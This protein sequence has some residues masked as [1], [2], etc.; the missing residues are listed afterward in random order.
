SAG[1]VTFYRLTCSTIPDQ[2]HHDGRGGQ[3]ADKPEHDRADAL[4]R[5][6]QRNRIGVI[7][8][9]ALHEFSPKWMPASARSGPD[10]RIGRPLGIEL[11]NRLPQELTSRS[12]H[13]AE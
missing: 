5:L 8:P 10:F 13:R 9:D 6:A 7:R 1:C 4:L 11:S 2:H 3:D 12:L